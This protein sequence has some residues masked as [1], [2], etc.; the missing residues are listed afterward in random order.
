MQQ[1]PI[2]QRPV[3]LT[4]LYQKSEAINFTMASH[5]QVGLLLRSLVA[6]KPKGNF[7]E[8]GTGMG[9]SLC[10]MQDGMDNSSSLTTIDNDP[11][12]LDIVSPYFEDDS[13]ITMICEDAAIWLQHYEGLD[14][15][16][17]F[18][19]AWPGKY[20]HLELI[21]KRIK[22]GGF[23][24]VDDLK[25]QANWPEG[26]EHN[27]ERLVQLLEARKDFT[28][29]TIDWATGTGIAIKKVV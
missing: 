21:L 15:D 18:A 4:A 16:L 12:L 24:V 8:L 26:H 10:W 23:Y 25:K 14:F 6:S 2:A 7:L 1:H 13:R 19:D 17:V 20:D 9:I 11:Q 27:V 5:E 28:I 22:P 29:I 3:P